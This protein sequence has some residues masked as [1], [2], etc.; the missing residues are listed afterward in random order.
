MMFLQADKYYVR[1]LQVIL[2]GPGENNYFMMYFSEYN[3]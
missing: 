3:K 1:K 2:Y